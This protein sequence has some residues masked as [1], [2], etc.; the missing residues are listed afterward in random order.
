MAR[1]TRTVREKNEAKRA[2]KSSI[3]R[4]DKKAKKTASAKSSAGKSRGASAG[5][6][7]VS[8]AKKVSSVNTMPKISKKTAAT[9]GGHLRS[10]DEELKGMGQT[11]ARTAVR[12]SANK[13]RTPAVRKQKKK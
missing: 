4:A 2:K 5:N 13:G 9:V 7:G 10:M 6:T 12:R 1:D 8:K 3:R 11:R